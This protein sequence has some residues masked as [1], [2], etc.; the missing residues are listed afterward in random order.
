MRWQREVE[1]VAAAVASPSPSWYT[2][3][4]VDHNDGSRGT[5]SQRYWLNTTMWSAPTGP[6]FVFINGEGTG[7]G[8]W[9]SAGEAAFFAEQYGAAVVSL[10]HRFY[11]ASYPV[12]SLDSA[13]LQLLTSEQALADLAQFVPWLQRTMGASNFSRVVTWGGSYAGAL[14]AFA[15]E[16]H[17]DVVHAAVA[18]SG[19]VQ[20][21]LDFEGYMAVVSASLGA[22]SGGGSPGCAD[23]F[24]AAFAALKSALAQDAAGTLTT[25]L[26]CQSSLNDS[27]DEWTFW[28]NIADDIAGVV[29]YN[30]EVTGELDIEGMCSVLAGV[31]HEQEPLVQAMGKLAATLLENFG[32]SCFDNN[33]ASSQIAPLNDSSAQPNQQ[34]VG[35]RQWIWQTCNEFGYYQTCGTDRPVAECLFQV[36]IALSPFLD[37]CR[38]VYGVFPIQVEQNVNDTLAYYGGRNG[39]AATSGVFFMDG[40]IDPW[41]ALAVLE[42]STP[43]SGA[44]LIVGTAHCRDLQTPG[45][46]DP[47]SLKDA[48][49]KLDVWLGQ[50]L[51]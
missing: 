20:A 28:E 18:S 27:N 23:D 9:S 34:G 25:M 15:R 13:A 47:Q 11:G 37:I 14:S 10:E 36:P 50:M 46:N 22:S 8:S 17:G 5:W 21:D 48:R 45:P 26:S 4:M 16:K 1:R 51:K 7:S 24:V 44:Q 33:F 39:A 41:H 42:T 12:N 40:T 29:Q 38:A 32:G 19:P 35:I 43:G 3:Q 6:L 2:E 49:Q 30:L 31:P